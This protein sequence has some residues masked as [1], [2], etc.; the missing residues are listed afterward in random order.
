MAAAHMF[1]GNLV[2]FKLISSY[3][4]EPLNTQQLCTYY[5]ALIINSHLRVI[6]FINTFALI[7]NNQLSALVIYALILMK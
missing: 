4:R 5:F 2:S 7:A 3:S 1:T 6:L